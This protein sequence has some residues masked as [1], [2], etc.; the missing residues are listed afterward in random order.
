MNYV[1]YGAG[2]VGGCIG[3]YL[4]RAK[5][6]VTLFARGAHLA[7]MQ[8]NG[9]TITTPEKKEE[10]IPVQAMEAKDY[11]GKADVVFVCMK[12]YGLDAV[13]EDLKRITTKE[14]IVIPILN[15]Y[16]TGAYLQ[17]K[18]D[19]QVLDGCI[20]IAA[21][22]QK[23]GVLLQKGEIFRLVYGPRDHR[24]HDGFKQIQKDLT[25]AG[26]EGV[27]S[28]NIQSEAYEKYTYISAAATC[29]LYYH[30]TAGDMQKEGEPRRLFQQLV[31]EM[32]LLGQA[33]GLDCDMDLVEK[34]TAILDTLLPLSS[35]SMQRDILQGRPSEIDGLI[36]EVGRLAEKYSIELD[37]YAKIIAQFQRFC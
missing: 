10:V 3:A 5:K 29:G 7:A 2:G 20:Y 28:E 37:G 17:E 1:V 16:G 26:I 34:N 25:E 23:P 21:E 18:L 6:D 11:Q 14:S 31:K 4:A 12:R 33:M 27:L 35:T 15:V 19:A 8:K 36:Y 30:A 9:L 24:I 22:I 13:I 32:V